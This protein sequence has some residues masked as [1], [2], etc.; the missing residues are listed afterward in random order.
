MSW[1]SKIWHD[2]V[3]SKVIAS[4][5]LAA[6]AT[7][8]AFAPSTRRWATESLGDISRL[9]VIGWF[10]LGVALGGIAV[11][12]ALRTFSQMRST[13]SGVQASE[14]GPAGVSG[15]RSGSAPQREISFPGLEVIDEKHDL[16]WLVRVDPQRWLNRGPGHVSDEGTIDGPFHADR[17]CMQRL[18][19]RYLP[20]SHI[21]VIEPR[22][23]RCGKQLFHGGLP[24]LRQAK[25]DLLEELR[26][27]HRRGKAMSG[28]ISIEHAGYWSSI[29]PMRR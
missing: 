14:G 3:W 29:E 27:L 1:A 20:H 5:I 16:Q 13:D 18:S 26:R 12:L 25:I 21:G 23:P 10:A 9:Q 17:E 7:A 15:H 24:E 11:V 6:L 28:P 8:A 4:V 19:V 2:P 22:C